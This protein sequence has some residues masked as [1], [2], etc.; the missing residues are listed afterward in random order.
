[1]GQ[2]HLIRWIKTLIQRAG[3]WFS[4]PLIAGILVAHQLERR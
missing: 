4:G 2:S 3:S 1:V